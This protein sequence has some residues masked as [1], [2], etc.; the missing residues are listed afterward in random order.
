MG[1]LKITNQP[2]FLN[3]IALCKKI[4]KVNNLSL[5]MSSN[6]SEGLPNNR[7]ATWESMSY[8]KN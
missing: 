3:G 8:K 5:S 1:G 6:L 7:S 4:E 2:S